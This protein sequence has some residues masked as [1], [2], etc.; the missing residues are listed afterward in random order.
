MVTLEVGR[1]GMHRYNNQD[2]SIL[3]GAL[4]ARNVLGGSHDIWN[5]NLERSYHEEFVVR[6]ASRTILFSSC[7]AKCNLAG[8][9]FLNND[10]IS[11][12]E[13]VA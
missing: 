2:H 8:M 12:P 4:A 9:I 10:L 6:R 11:M 1:N 5:V 7:G 3:T 13:V